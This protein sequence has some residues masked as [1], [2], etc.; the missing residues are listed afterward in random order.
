MA[1]PGE[2]FKTG[3]AARLTGRFGFVGQRRRVTRSSRARSEAASET[4][5]WIGHY[6][7][8]PYGGES[9]SYYWRQQIYAKEEMAKT[10]PPGERREVSLSHRGAGGPKQLPSVPADGRWTQGAASDFRGIFP[11]CRRSHNLVAIADLENVIAGEPV[12]LELARGLSNQCRPVGL[13]LTVESGS[14]MTG[15]LDRRTA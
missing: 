8:P 7:F 4:S 10:G 12:V 14:P 13:H 11:G 9:G 3:S 15:F 1:P 6:G 2:P 5:R